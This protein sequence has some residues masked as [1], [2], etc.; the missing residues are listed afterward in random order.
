MGLFKPHNFAVS[1]IVS[2]PG[3]CASAVSASIPRGEHCG[4][5]GEDGSLLLPLS[6]HWSFGCLAMA[7]TRKHL[8]NGSL[9]GNCKL[10]LPPLLHPFS[11]D[12]CSC[13]CTAASSSSAQPAQAWSQK[14]PPVSC[15]WP[16]CLLLSPVRNWLLFA[17][18]VKGADSRRAVTEDRL[19]CLHMGS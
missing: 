4:S 14:L 11:G 8:L 18:D 12:L 16:C 2:V 6:C 1:R 19:S 13:H 9:T 17:L 15:S 3:L 7:G 10:A 5:P